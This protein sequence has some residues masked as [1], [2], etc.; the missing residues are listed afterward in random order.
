MTGLKPSTRYY[1]IV[2]DASAGFSSPNW[3]I[4]GK[5]GD[6]TSGFSIAV[7]GDVGVFN[8]EHSIAML[9]NATLR[10]EVDWLWHVGDISY[11]DDAFLHYPFHFMYESVYNEYMNAVQ[12]MASR[13]AYMVLPGNHEA[14]CHSLPCF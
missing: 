1:Y 11:A 2:G 5:A 6:D 3:F 12:P 9:N 10:G 14:E 8:S 4:S 7:F 13:T